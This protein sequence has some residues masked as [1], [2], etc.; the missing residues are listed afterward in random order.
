MRASGDSS[1]SRNA[2]VASP[3]ATM[4]SMVSSR[5]SVRARSAM[6]T[7]ALSQFLQRA[8][9][10]LLDGPFGTVESGRYV[11]D[12][13]L[14]D[15]PHLNH[16]PLQVGQPLDLLIQRDP[17]LD[18]LELVRVRHVGRRLVRVTGAFAPVVRERVRGDAEQP[19]RH[20]QAP[21]FKA[22]DGGQRLLEDLRRDVFRGGP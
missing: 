5:R 11:A 2:A 1:G 3:R 17:T 22:A 9:L 10:K 4:A 6:T 20:R 12:A 7:H 19:D 16:L 13:L 14:L 15:K 18:V 21:P 8:Q